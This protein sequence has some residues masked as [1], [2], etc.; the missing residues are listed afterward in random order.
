[1]QSY[2]INTT[3]TREAQYTG[4]TPH[5]G[6]DDKICSFERQQISSKTIRIRLHSVT[7]IMLWAISSPVSSS[8]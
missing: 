2:K 7:A 4:P 1:M 6:E 3:E 5:N 8:Q